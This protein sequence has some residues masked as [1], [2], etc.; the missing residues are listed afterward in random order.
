MGPQQITMQAAYPQGM[1][2]NQFISQ[3]GIPGQMG[4]PFGEPTIIYG[5]PNQQRYD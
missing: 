2:P 3:V 4:G 1:Y 5:D